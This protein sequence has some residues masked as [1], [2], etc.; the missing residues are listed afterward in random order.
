MQT[1]YPY[2]QIL[3]LFFAIIFLGYVFFD[4]VIFSSLKDKFGE[5]FSYIKQT[6]GKKA[7]KIMPFCLLGLFLTGGAMMSSWVGSKAGGYLQTP[8]QQVFMLKFA[9]AVIIGLGV[10]LNLSMRAMKKEPFKFMQ[11]HFHKVVLV[12]GFLI[13]LFAKMM[14]LVG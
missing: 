8:L 10:V 5:N 13:V 4:V 2:M 9:L 1:I 3:H 6:I 14:F 11:N 7:I 12:F